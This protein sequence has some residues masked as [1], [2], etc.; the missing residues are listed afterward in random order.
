MLN[1]HPDLAL[2][3]ETHFVMEAYGN[4][5]QFGDL[6]VGENRQQ[7]ARWL[8]CRKETR[9][10]RLEI[11]AD[12]AL[13]ALGAAPPTL[14]SV[15][16]T[17]FKLF[18]DHTGKRRWGDKRPMYVQR[19]PELFAMF[20]D[21]QV[22]IIVR[23]PRAVVASMKKLGWPKAVI[24]DGT[25]AGGTRRWLNAV[26]AGR[27]AVRRYRRDQVLQ[28]RYEDLVI[29]PVRVLSG[30]CSF[31]E[32][33]AGGLKAMLEYHVGGSDIPT[34]QQAKY[35]PKVARPVTDEAV[36]SWTD[37]LTDDEVAQVERIAGREM[38]RYGYQ[39]TAP[40]SGP[41]TDRLA[42]T[43]VDRA[44]TLVRPAASGNDDAV[45]V[46]ARLTTAQRRRHALLQRL[47]VDG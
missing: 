38:R 23:D 5:H 31:L 26:S 20:P 14:G 12:E 36:R 35:H 21:A 37:V 11:P 29:D 28:I 25:V 19:L 9:F 18:A 3:R 7:L 16:G 32:L 1:A 34:R 39:L 46:A 41:T 47:H 43:A 2:P 6:R 22:V 4:R 8:V 33:D 10:D 17:G 45:P 27:M 44:K 30:V 24:H 15:I 13:R 42:T 40:Q